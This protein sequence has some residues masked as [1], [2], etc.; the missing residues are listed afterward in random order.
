MTG[1]ITFAA[2][3]TW[4]TFNQSTA[5]NAGTASKLATARTI[6]LTGDVTGS[7][8]FDGSADA[9]I[10]TIVAD[11]SHNHTYL[12]D[13]STITY[14]ANYLQWTNLSGQNGTGYNGSTPYNPTND[15]YHHIIA[16]HGNAGG[17]YVDIALCFHS[18]NHYI[19]RLAN[20]TLTTVKLWND[21]NDGS[22]SGLDADLLD[23]NHASA[24]ALSAH[25]HNYA[26]S[27]TAGGAATSLSGFTNTNSSS[28]IVGADALTNNG[29]GYVNSISLFSQTD[30]ALYGQAYST[31]WVHQ[32]FG[33]YRTGQ[34]AVRG[35]N[36]GTWQAWRTVWDSGN[37]TNL[38]QLTNGPGYTTNTGTV[39]SV[40]AGSY[41]TGGT[42][43]TSGTLAVD[44]TSANTASKVVARDASGNFSANVITAVDF[45]ATSDA[46]LKENVGRLNGL[47]AV[48]Q[49][50]PVEFTWKNTGDRSYGVLAQELEQVLPDLV[51]NDIAGHK[52]VSYTPLIAFLISAVQAL[53]SEVQALKAST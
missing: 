50:N 49:I 38:N 27:A 52:S 7:V 15:W 48:L 30:G 31:S 26:G 29:I 42:I 45:N 12:S 17:Y 22:G 47:N 16:N 51:H 1:A 3:Q 9:S 19:N 34:L 40:A 21:G 28:P 20:G 41:L 5:G 35:K 8:S 46:R 44:A 14:G 32:I 25:T 37:L 13:K 43:T 39:T 18:N 24:F 53:H 2:G 23:G 6:S 36:N 10:T 11:D 4:P 33:D